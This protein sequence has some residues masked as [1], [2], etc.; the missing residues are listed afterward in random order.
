[1][2]GGRPPAPRDGYADRNRHFYRAEVERH[3]LTVCGLGYGRAE[4]QAAALRGPGPGRRPERRQRGYELVRR[5]DALIK[6][7]QPDVLF[8]HSLHEIHHDHVLVHRA[9]LASMRLRPMDLF[10]YQ[11]SSCKP[12]PSQ[13]HARAWVDI[14]ETIDAKIEAIAAHRSQFGGRGL[15]VESFRDMAR[16]VAVPV[17]LQYAEPLDIHCMRS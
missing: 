5:L 4:S 11:P 6:Q 9:V 1:M 10:F 16:A 14:S 2:I 15:C 3:G 13:F 8:A 7:H 12:R 17:G